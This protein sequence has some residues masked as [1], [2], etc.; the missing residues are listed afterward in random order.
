MSSS[1]PDDMSVFEEYSSSIEDNIL[2][3]TSAESES[4]NDVDNSLHGENT[5]QY[6][7][8]NEPSVN[9]VTSSIQQFIHSTLKSYKK[10]WKG[11]L[12]FN[13]IRERRVNSKYYNILRN[14][15]KNTSHKFKLYFPLVKYSPSNGFKG[16]GFQLLVKD[17][18][19]SSMITSGFSIVKGGTAKNKKKL[20]GCYRINCFR[21][22]L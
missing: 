1:I 20:H 2:S 19:L 17:L 6:I 11:K 16:T 15:G 9:K 13:D 4:D 3:E 22:Q 8:E 7:I 18:Q 21:C 5:I 10:E 14:V 12:Y